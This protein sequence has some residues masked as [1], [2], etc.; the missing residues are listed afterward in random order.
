MHKLLLCACLLLPVTLAVADDWP[1]W[2]GPQRDNVWRETGLIERFPENGPKILWR[3][4][5]AGGYAGPSVADGMV[6][7]ADY[8][9][10][11]NVKIDNFARAESTGIERV[12]GL[13]EATGKVQWTH[14]YPVTYSISY[15][16]GPRT[17]PLVHEGKLYAQGAEGNLIC[18]T[19]KTGEVVW[20][21]DLKATY[22]TKSALWG[23]SSQPLIDGKKLILLA[24]GTGSH[25]VA[26][27]KDT[28]EEI[29]RTGTAKE[30]G[31]S[32]PVIFEQAGVRQL[33]LTQPD[34]VYAV[35]PETGKE[36]WS[37]PYQADN[38]SII[39]TP[40][41]IGN[42]LFI[43]GF[44]NRN[45]LLELASDKP[46]AKTLWKDKAKHAMAPINVQPFLLDGLLYGYD[47]SGELRCVE[48]PSGE[49]KWA[50]PEPLAARKQGSG[51]VFLVREGETNRFWMFAESGDLIIGTLSPSGF[52]ELDRAHLLE[53]TNN[54]F[55]REVVWCAPAFA[56]KRMYVRNDAELI[57]VDLAK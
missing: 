4:A 55:G 10:K 39:M 15:P 31:Y 47:S 51:T 8:V 40:V 37:Q 29:W 7:V 49:I 9:T 57:C 32:P 44:N 52:E 11:D 42:L 5:V 48:F 16:A 21:M 14:E 24:G 22:N 1:Q 13:D 28:G 30:Q 17:T 41:K 18:F 35:D 43:G 25:C 23:Y 46:G 19:A 26:L 53:P 34:A 20:S 36:L 6:Y 50:T 54:A 2:M 38:G 56:N 12:M 33:V 45:L 3:A 27:N